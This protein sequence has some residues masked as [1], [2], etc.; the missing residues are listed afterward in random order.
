MAATYVRAA[1]G[2]GSFSATCDAT[3]DLTG[4]DTLLVWAWTN[5]NTGLTNVSSAA[6]DPAGANLAMTAGTQRSG[7][8]VLDTAGNLRGFAIS[9][10]ALS[11]SKTVRVTFSDG[12]T[13]TR[14]WV[15]GYTG[16][17]AVSA[18]VL[19]DATSGSVTSTAVSS[20]TGSTV[21]GF[22]AQN[23][24]DSTWTPT[25]PTATVRSVLTSDTAYV[26]GVVWEEAGAAS[27]TLEGTV[28]PGFHWV[29]ESWSITASGGGSSSLPLIGG[30]TSRLIG[31]RLVA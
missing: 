27:V 24:V 26:T 1:F 23:G 3:T 13:N 15:V 14:A 17:T 9:G 25:S 12:D 5:A 22:F 8:T 28:S 11:G 2:S 29:A 30:S 7:A 4:I 18:S 19:H 10:L 20:A 31:G 6:V 16:G 21:V